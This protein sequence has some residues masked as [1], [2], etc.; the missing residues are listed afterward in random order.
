MNFPETTSA[1]KL[2]PV[3]QMD[4]ASNPMDSDNQKSK[5]NFNPQ[6]QFDKKGESISQI[7]QNIKFPF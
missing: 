7:K 6:F 3:F 4:I 1:I 5:Y 2:K